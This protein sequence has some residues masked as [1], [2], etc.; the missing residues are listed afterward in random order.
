M[1][2]FVSLRCDYTTKRKIYFDDHASGGFKYWPCLWCDDHIPLKQR[3]RQVMLHK[4]FKVSFN[5]D[6]KH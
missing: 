1:N 6:I 2:N 4:K 5:N 3:V